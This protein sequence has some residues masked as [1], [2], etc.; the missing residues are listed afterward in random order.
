[1]TPTWSTSLLERSLLELTG[2]APPAHY[3][4]P[5]NYVAITDRPLSL[6]L[7]LSNTQESDSLYVIMGS[8]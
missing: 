8:F 4:Q 2:K 3:R 6:E 7:G 1:V 5:R